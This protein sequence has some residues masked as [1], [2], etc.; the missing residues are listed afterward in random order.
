VEG[1][2]LELDR[3]VGELQEAARRDG[4]RAVEGEVGAGEAREDELVLT[5]DNFLIL[6]FFQN[7]F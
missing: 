5:V 1:V 4:R 6:T 3:A 2:A 7:Y